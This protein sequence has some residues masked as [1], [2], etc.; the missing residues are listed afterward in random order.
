[1]NFVSASQ[2]VTEQP[3]PIGYIPPSSSASVMEQE[4]V[5]NS[6]MDEDVQEEKDKENEQVCK[7][8]KV[9]PVRIELTTLR[10]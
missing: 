6:T 2:L 5:N 3:L 4:N 8:K 10:L 7:K 1:M 9:P